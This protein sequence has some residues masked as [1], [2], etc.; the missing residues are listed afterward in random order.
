ME[1]K[2]KTAT[3]LSQRAMSSEA[4]ASSSQTSVIQQ[5][6]N[7]STK[8]TTTVADASAGTGL[9]ISINAYN[10]SNLTINFNKINEG[11]IND[12]KI[13]EGGK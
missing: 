1:N 4:V 8:E 2:T 5:Q 6:I 11:N 3:M 9:N 10:N 13:L 7:L 12:H